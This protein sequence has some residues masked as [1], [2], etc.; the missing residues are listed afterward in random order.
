[1]ERPCSWVQQRSGM[2]NQA[3]LIVGFLVVFDC[4]IQFAVRT[5]HDDYRK[6]QIS[7]CM[8]YLYAK[9]CRESFLTVAWKRAGVL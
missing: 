9:F 6:L 1:M 2:R 4:V 5:M 7:E 3:E 8:S